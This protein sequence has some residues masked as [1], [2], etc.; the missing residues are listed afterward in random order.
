[1]LGDEECW[2]G[3]KVSGESVRARRVW[4]AISWDLIWLTLV[5]HSTYSEP[6]H[7]TPH[8]TT[9]LHTPPTTHCNTA[10]SLV[11]VHSRSLNSGQLSR[12]TSRHLT[13]PLYIV[14]IVSG[15]AC[16]VQPK[17]LLY[18]SPPTQQLIYQLLSIRAVSEPLVGLSTLAPTDCSSASCHSDGGATDPTVLQVAEAPTTQPLG[19]QA[20][21]AP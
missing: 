19:H 6:P 10:K 20:D 7:S 11:A 18:R 15:V 3:T 9:P 16:R 4:L 17:P 14:L 21:S 1:M 13:L 12:D 2:A 8:S 5:V